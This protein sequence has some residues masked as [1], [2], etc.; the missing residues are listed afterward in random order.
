MEAH[1]A[2][3]AALGR[4]G[5]LRTLAPA[6]GADFAS[7]DYLGLAQSEELRQAA[8]AALARGVPLGAGGS[9]L[10]RG[11]HPE[12]EALEAEAAAFFGAEAALFFAGGFAANAALVSTL[13]RRGDLVVYDELIHASVH[14]G[15]A[16]ASSA[17]RVEAVATRHADA[18]G[19]DDAIRTWRAKG[20]RGRAWIAAETLYSMDGDFAPL[21][22]L[23]AVAERHDA[24]L[25][26][27]EAH[28]TGVYG[29]AGR[30][31]AAHLEG[32]ANVVTLHTC[33]KAL[34][35]M[36]ALVCLPR[37][38]KDYMVNRSRPFI[39]ATAPSPLLAATVR[40][41][42]TLVEAAQDR[43]DRLMARIAHARG[44]LAGIGLPATS[45]Q[46]QKVILGSDRRATAIAAALQAQGFDVRAIRPPTVP[47][48][49][50]R[51]R[52]ALTLNVPETA[53]D[54]LV[55]ALRLALAAEPGTKAERSAP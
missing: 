28:A 13:P 12:H 19:V 54:A 9:R 27:D 55:D 4:R 44:A 25:L 48:G 29:P 38:L 36:G 45:S 3:L 15:L 47:E 42:L 20:G 18:G 22:D 8:A 1:E 53:L 30:G 16:G 17:E 46:I 33:G 52:V 24:M 21:D 5:R 41:A 23:C 50:A 2:A 37:G 7:N 39:Y 11:N 32:R 26:L 43:R 35:V 34:G 31:L 40:A 10:L 14:E 6:Q 49:T 51:L